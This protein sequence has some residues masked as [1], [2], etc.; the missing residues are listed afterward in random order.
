[1][2]TRLI[3]SALLSTLIAAPAL[4]QQHQPD[5]SFTINVPNGYVA[6]APQAPVVQAPIKNHIAPV[7]VPVQRP[8]VQV[9]PPVPQTNDWQERDHQ[10]RERDNFRNRMS[11]YNRQVAQIINDRQDQQIDRIVEGVKSG[12][13]GRD[14]FVMLMQNQKQL[15]EIERG[16]LADGF[17]ARDEYEAM[18]RALDDEDRN[19]RRVAFDRKPYR[20]K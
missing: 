8:V 9:L 13:V 20:G 4:A 17:W 15:R 18:V 11:E 5:W 2:K 7:P 3:T 6:P 1:M 12:R 19:I 10:W 14:Q 16:Y